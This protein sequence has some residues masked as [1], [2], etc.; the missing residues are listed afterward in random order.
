MFLQVQLCIDMI[1]YNSM[2][3]DNYLGFRNCAIYKCRM[4]DLLAFSI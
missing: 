4:E 2:V 1:E 3:F